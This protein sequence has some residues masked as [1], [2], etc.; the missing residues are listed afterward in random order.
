MKKV[1][2]SLLA[3]L[4]V[5]VGVG[6]FWLKGNLD[7]LVAQAIRDYGSAMTQASVQVGSVKIESSD[8]RGTLQGLVIGNPAGFKTPHALKAERVELEVDIATLASEVIVIKKIAVLA[9][10]IIYEK[11]EAMTNFDALQK[12][13]AHYLGPQKKPQ[14]G[15]KE[16]KFIVQDFVVQGAK[17]QASAAFMNGKTVTVPLPDIHLRDLGKAKGGATAGELGQE[18]TAAIKAKLSGAVSFDSLMKS[19]GKALDKAG[20]AI[21]GLFQ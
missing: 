18:M 10:D 16:K 5:A 15:D 14:A 2:Y 17:A 9:P 12:N 13:I 19:T 11:G 1:I 7:S 6:V 21:K 20:Q 3:L 8:G 4:L